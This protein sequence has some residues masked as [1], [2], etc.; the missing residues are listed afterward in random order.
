VNTGKLQ[1]LIGSIPQN[2][3]YR[4]PIKPLPER[5]MKTKAPLLDCYTASCRAGC[6]LEQDIP[7]Y[8]R[9][10]GR[11]EY[12]EALRV[13]T[14]RNPLPFMTGTICSHRCMDKCMRNFYEE[15]VNIRAV[16]LEAAEKAYGALMDE[17]KAPPKSGG[18]I[19]VIGGGP[20]GLSAAYFLARM[21]RPVTIF[22]KKDSLGGIVRHVIPEFRIAGDSID[23][24]IA[25]VEAMGV[26]VRL[27]SEVKNPE[28]LRKEGFETIIIAAGAW[29]PGVLKLQEG[30]ALG[31]LEF[32]EDMKRG[33][34]PIK[35]GKNVVVIGGGN[36]AMDA[37][38][39]AKRA[40]GVQ[41]VSIVYR[42]T[43]RYMPADEEELRLTL[44]DGVE[45]H[46]L[47]APHALK[48]GMLT[49]VK[50]T[51]GAPDASGRRSPVPTEE[52]TEIPADTVISAI[53]D[54]VDG[55]YYQNCG[56]RTDKS[57]KAAV[58]TDTLESS[59]PGVYVIGDALRG[60]ATVAEAIADA[61][62]CSEAIAGAAKAAKKAVGKYDS[63]NLNPDI[64]PALDKK[65]TLCCDLESCHDSQRCLEC[66][67]LCE[68]CA[69]VCPNRANMVIEADGRRQVV[70]LDA[71]CN[72]CGNCEVFCPYEG[73]PYKDKFTMFS[74]EEDFAD[75]ENQGFLP[76]AD[77]KFRVRLDGNISDYAN[78][79]GLPDGIRKLVT[80][81]NAI[82][83]F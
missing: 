11:G 75:S 55:G 54:A 42:R 82:S 73:A 37:A 46:E 59:L 56:I 15:P 53:G 14:D 3:L 26:D 47:L 24:D 33:S 60:P 67:T 50:M 39:A 7:A 20:A 77:G 13:I 10:A 65:G 32:L 61:I 58:N 28:D 23:R 22:E 51:L 6:P 63:L 62:K 27:N 74:C 2:P 31:A 69:D 29:K 5:K 68:C 17:I 76:L 4:K 8:L 83:L 64:G 48:D 66:A 41:R 49:C 9:L 70:H 72:E 52:K 81:C 12:L 18:K 80:D 43:R 21:G 78:L 19:A 57:G 30:R 40:E 79:S 34:I 25:L 45:F 38:R 1:E 35:L 44:E 16:K 71:L 36:T